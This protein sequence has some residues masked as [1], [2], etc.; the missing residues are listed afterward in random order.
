[1]GHAH[2]IER[3]RPARTTPPDAGSKR[4]W[5]PC[6]AVALVAMSLFYVTLKDLV[7]E[8]AAR[9]STLTHA[10]TRSFVEPALPTLHQA[11]LASAAIQ[12]PARASAQP[13]AKARPRSDSSFVEVHKCITPEGGAAYSDGPCPDG[14]SA[15]TLRLPRDLHATASL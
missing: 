15:S 4:Y 7:H 9:A 8:S 2:T 1:M 11:P 6:L 12:S 5:A 10:A 13:P 14:A 3:L